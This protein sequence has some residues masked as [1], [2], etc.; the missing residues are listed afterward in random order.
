MTDDPKRQYEVIADTYESLMESRQ[1]I[2]IEGIRIRLPTPLPFPRLDVGAGTGLVSKVL[3]FA[4]V[5]LDI[6]PAML[7]HAP[8]ERIVGDMRHLPFR[9][10]SFG[11]VVS[12]SA[13]S[14]SNDFRPAID[15]MI[16][17]LKSNYSMYLSVL[18]TEDL[19]GVERYLKTHDR[20]SAVERYYNGPDMLFIA[21]RA[22]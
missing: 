8:H 14:T 10:E 19:G 6:S 4:F 18:P 11:L 20:I 5:S 2:K 22:P 3:G 15:E 17:V 21:R 16:R 7:T 9:D 12:I 1:R 13:L